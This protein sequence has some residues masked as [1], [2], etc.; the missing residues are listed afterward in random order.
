MYERNKSKASIGEFIEA[1]LQMLTG[2]TSRPE[3]PMYNKIVTT[4]H[5]CGH[6]TNLEVMNDIMP[7]SYTHLDVYK[8]QSL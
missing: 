1:Y 5:E 4:S 8:R 2:R 6:A 7:V 3:M